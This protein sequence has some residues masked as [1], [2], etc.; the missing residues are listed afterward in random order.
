MLVEHVLADMKFP[1]ARWIQGMFEVV[2]PTL[3][4]G[5]NINRDSGGLREGGWALDDG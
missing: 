1:L 4:G 5:C 3:M 2:W